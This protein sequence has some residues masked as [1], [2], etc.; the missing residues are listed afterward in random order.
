MLVHLL[1]EI[2][3]TEGVTKCGIA[4]KRKD[5][6]P[7]LTTAWHTDVTCPDCAPT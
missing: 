7:T 3:S 4:F 5:K 2:T 1:K 6:T